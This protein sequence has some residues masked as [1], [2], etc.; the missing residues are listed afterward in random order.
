MFWTNFRMIVQNVWILANA[1][2]VNYRHLLKTALP[3]LAMFLNGPKP[4]KT[5]PTLEKKN[6]ALKLFAIA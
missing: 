5:Y 4:F 1:Q 3:M 2:W 6:K